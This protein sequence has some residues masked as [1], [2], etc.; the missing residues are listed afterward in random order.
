MA[1]EIFVKHSNV[2]QFRENVLSVCGFVAWRK[3]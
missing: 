3:T 1:G 2:Q